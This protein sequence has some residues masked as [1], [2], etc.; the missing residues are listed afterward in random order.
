MVCFRLFFGCGLEG[1]RGFCRF[2]PILR[3]V[4]GA[5]SLHRLALA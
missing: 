4:L 5:L 1:V 3:F 2:L